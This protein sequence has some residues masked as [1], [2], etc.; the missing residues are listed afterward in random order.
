MKNN[1]SELIQKNKDLEKLNVIVSN[2]YLS[3]R[4][5]IID[6]HT[7]SLKDLI[8]A[9]IESREKAKE[10]YI[11]NAETTGGTRDETHCYR[12]GYSQAQ[13]DTIKELRAIKELLDNKA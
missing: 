2:L 10:R 4:Q 3:Q 12:D 8:D 13:D 5:K 11:P 6:W 9:V 1:I 7:Q